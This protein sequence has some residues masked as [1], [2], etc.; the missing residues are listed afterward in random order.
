MDE[1]TKTAILSA[2]RIE[3]T[4][5]DFYLLA[6][7]RVA[8]P[9]TRELLVKLACEEFEHLVGFIR[10]YPGEQIDISPVVCEAVNGKDP[11]YWDLLAKY[12]GLDTRE[13]AL[14]LAI[15]EERSCVELYST[16]VT[17]IRIPEV[18][19]MFTRALAETE[20]HLSAI[21]AEYALCRG[22]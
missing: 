5:H 8:D 17:T 22:K 2:I 15:K 20:M 1:Y 3:K 7:S 19:N 6:A 14:S 11:G 9:E 4:S 21:E 13:K 16:F 12:N 18:H 10:L